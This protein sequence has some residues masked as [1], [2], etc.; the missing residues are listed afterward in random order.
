MK[1]QFE[2]TTDFTN[3]CNKILD[4]LGRQDY[5]EAKLV[6][7]VTN[8]KKYYPKTKRYDNYTSE[9]VTRVIEELK[10]KG[11]MDEVKF[12]TRMLE[13]YLG[14]EYGI[15]TIER[16]MRE[17]KYKKEN[18][19]EVIDSYRRSGSEFDYTKIEKVAVKKKEQWEKKYYDDKQK[20]YQIKT[21]L[22]VW[23]AQKGFESGEI[24]QIITRIYK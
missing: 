8:L 1:D 4:Y 5:S 2:T 14:R 16:K 20:F 23:L 3:I 6:E 15:R 13:A 11:V 12:L 9:N 21:K 18:I 24:K 22:Y 19:V 17:R 7:K 10:K